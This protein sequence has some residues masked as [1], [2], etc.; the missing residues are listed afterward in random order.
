MTGLE[1]KL[2]LDVG[3]TFIKC[4]DGRS[5]PVDSQGPASGITASLRAAV[6]NTGAVRHIAVA[7]PGP[8]DYTTG[9][10]LMKHKFASV[11]GQTFRSVAVVPDSVTLRFIH[12]VNCMLLGEVVSGKGKDFSNV[13]LVSLGTG[14]GFAMQVGG[15]ILQTPEGSPLYSIYNLPFRGGVLEDFVSKRGL[16]R[17]YTSLG[18]MTPSDLTVKALSLLARQGDKAAGE[19]FRQ[20]GQIVGEAIAP[21]LREH[22]VQCLLFG[23][24]ISRSFDLMEPAVRDSLAGVTSLSHIGAVSAIDNATF[25]GLA[26]L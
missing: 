1:D 6:G 24:Q 14:L 26:V 10:F 21:L 3:G 13:A 18:G 11:Y 20:A 7:M 16:L 2:L 25:N 8:F 5:V 23:G 15:K 19:A 22:S 12:D 9:T 17:L 4:S